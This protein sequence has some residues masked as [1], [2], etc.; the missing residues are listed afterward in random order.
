MFK[1]TNGQCIDSLS[2]CDGLADCS[3]QSDE[4]QSLCAP[5]FKTC[6][7]SAFRCN[8]GACISK[9]AKCNGK[10]DCIDGSDE[11]LP[12]CKK[13]PLVISSNSPQTQQAQVTSQSKCIYKE[14]YSC[15]SGQCI[16]ITSICD[17][18]SDC[19]DKSDETLELCNSV[20]C[21][22]NTF[23]CNYGAC[24]SKQRKCDGSRNCADGSDE[25]G[26]NDTE[27]SKTTTSATPITQITWKP[28]SQTTTLESFYQTIKP[29]TQTTNKGGCV[30]PNVEGTVYSLF[31]VESD[32]YPI[33][34][35]GT[36]V[37]L[38]TTVEENCNEGY[39]KT[40]SNRIIIC[41]G[42]G[43]WKPTF[44]KLCLKRCPPVFSDSLDV[45]CVFQGKKENCSTSSAPDTILTPK[46]KV[47][48]T[49]P[50]GQIETPIKLRCQKDG[51]WSNRLYTCIPYCG[52]P[53]T[54]HQAL[55]LGGNEAV[56]GS[57]PW[58][59]GVYRKNKNTFNLICGGSLIAPNL[60]VS[61]AHCFW[62]EGLIERILLND[63]RYKISV[64]KYKSDI[65][66]KDNAF[67]QI[68]DVGLIYL[69]ESYYGSLGNHA[70]DIAILVLPI[71]IPMS[72]VVSPVCMDWSK[73]YSISNGII[74][75]VVGW[76]K[77]EKMVESS[78]LLE[79]NLP[80]IDHQTCR[81]MYINGFQNFVTI[82]KFCAGTKTGQGVHQGDSGAGLTFV[83]NSLHFLTGIV[84]VKD[85]A[86]NDS[87]AV[88]T[89]V[90]RHIGW[91]YEIFTNYT[92]ASDSFFKTIR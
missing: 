50:N 42:N 46:C 32:Q 79:A 1:C 7:S 54:P 49:V 15:K 87:I 4:T 92:Y 65:T 31:Q 2:I 8:Y 75:Q 45:E 24:I 12:E 10:N 21:P 72:N 48:H 41:S 83:H 13:L 84:S 53:Y 57:A 3:D 66:I 67:T 28:I 62:Q 34:S 33:L 27:N 78:V 61:A 38:N 60:V 36:Y 16:D 43:K 71:K 81:N 74:G 86:T 51:N 69:K 19:N 37:N 68:V 88:F 52:R 56:Y 23:K 9:S 18:V 77:T 20:V 89:D 58:N 29:P 85:P 5:L 59:V 14:E 82:D 63:G 17:G 25:L 70:D 26:C 73:Q 47:T 90:N 76:G 6:P 11:N 22:K 30:I 55:I 80:Y 64:G 35:P 39:Y 40:T 91:I 44:D